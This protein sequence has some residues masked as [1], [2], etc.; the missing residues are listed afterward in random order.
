MEPNLERGRFFVVFRNGLGSMVL[1]ALSCRVISPGVRLPLE[2]PRR[3][4]P[5]YPL[6]GQFWSGCLIR[7]STRC[8][9]QDTALPNDPRRGIPWFRAEPGVGNTQMPVMERR[10]MKPVNRIRTQCIANLTALLVVTGVMAGGTSW[11]NSPSGQNNELAI[12]LNARKV[13]RQADGKEKLVTA[14][15]AFPGEVIQYDAL[16]LNQSGKAIRNVSPTL[17]IPNGMVFV[18]ESATPAPAEASL[19]GRKF[20]PIP[21]K[22]KVTLANGEE[23]EEEVPPTQYRALRWHLGGMAAGA[24]ATVTARTKLVPAG[25]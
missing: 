15:R 24:Q 2:P 13:V 19:D 16:Y 7:S 4:G 12:S 8:S 5:C 17:P 14:D 22:R 10:T 20:E 1:A 6:A 18:P 21:L 3:Y 11:G 23:K 9:F 25:Q